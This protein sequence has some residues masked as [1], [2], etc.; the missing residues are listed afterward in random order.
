[1]WDE[2]D[3]CWC[4]DSNECTNTECF[5]HLDNKDDKEKIFTC[6]HLMNTKYCSI[7]EREGLMER[8]VR[9]WVGNEFLEFEVHDNFN[10]EDELYKAV[11]QYVIESLSI[12][13][14]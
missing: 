1:M 9:V 12:E 7:N 13:I 5:R 3:I 6:S 2:S 10:S 8:T 4:V 11:F 14:I